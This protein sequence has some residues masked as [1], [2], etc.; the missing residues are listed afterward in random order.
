MIFDSWQRF[1]FEQ[2][3]RDIGRLIE[4]EDYLEA[5]IRISAYCTG[6]LNKLT[7]P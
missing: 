7:T 6:V 1:A 5:T 2:E 4:L 3:R